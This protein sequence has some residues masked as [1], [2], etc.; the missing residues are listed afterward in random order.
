MR[1]RL[2][3]IEARLR[4][5]IESSAQLLPWNS[6]QNSLAR[7]LVDAMDQTIQPAADGVSRAPSIYTITMHPD[8]LSFWQSR[9][10]LFDSLARILLDAAREA[11]VTFATSPV[12]RLAG[13]P[14][15][16]LDEIFVR[17]SYP[18]EGTGE[19]AVVE[20]KSGSPQ[21]EGLDPRPYNAF[22]IVEGTRIFPLRLPVV[23]IGRRLDNQLVIDDPRVSRTHAQ[24]RAVRGRYVLFDLNSTGGTFVNSIRVTQQSLQPGDV[25]SLAGVALIYGEDSPPRRG[26][27]AELYPPPGLE[28]GSTQAY[29]L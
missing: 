13:D 22:L 3:Q 25:I 7:Q 26:Q 24:L 4:T 18:Q 9:Q 17:A 20:L 21:H 29:P 15:L 23:N 19:T 8:N 27:T 5:F 2:D 1:S 11:D 12:I 28:D 10:D 14:S 6:R 16:T